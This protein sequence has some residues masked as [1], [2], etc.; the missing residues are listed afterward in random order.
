MKRQHKT[1]VRIMT[2][3]PGNVHYNSNTQKKDT[4]CDQLKKYLNISRF[5]TKY[6]TFISFECVKS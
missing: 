1:Y 5:L 2:K 4:F 3:Y 6:I